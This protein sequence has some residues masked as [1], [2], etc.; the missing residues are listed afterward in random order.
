[1][2]DTKLSALTELDATPAD[3]DEVYIRDVSEDP[4][5]ES[6]RITIA[7]L[8]PASGV[9]LEA[10]VALFQAN[11]GTGTVLNPSNINDNNTGSTASADAEG[12][13]SVVDYAKVVC[14]KRWR[15]YGATAHTGDGR[16]KIQYY[17]LSTHAYAD[18]DTAIV[19]R[20]TADWSDFVTKA[21]VLTDKIK[22]ISTTIDTVGANQF[23]EMEVIY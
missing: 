16:F 2:A 4:A 22:V 21:E 5:D 11:A 19:V 18:W 13:Y 7:N 9:A 12:E 3:D 10:T 8:L 15:Y 23:Y 14:I 20:T 1:M 6:K 17:N